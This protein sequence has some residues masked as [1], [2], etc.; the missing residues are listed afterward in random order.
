MKHTPVLA[1]RQAFHRGP[2]PRSPFPRAVEAL[3]ALA[4]DRPDHVGSP[5]V[6]DL[7]VALWARLRQPARML[8]AARTPANR[9]HRRRV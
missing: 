7:I 6:E 2:S 1:F 4:Q 8:K 5:R 9:V 3:A